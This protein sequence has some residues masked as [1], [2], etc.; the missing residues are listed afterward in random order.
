MLIPDFK[1]VHLGE[2][3]GGAKLASSKQTV[4]AERKH[5]PVL[6]MPGIN[7]LEDEK[8]LDIGSAGC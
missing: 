3:I 6:E 5:V 4:G 2:A 7:E 1:V 8:T